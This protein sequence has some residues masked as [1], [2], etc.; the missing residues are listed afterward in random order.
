MRSGGTS[1][2]GLRRPDP[3][4]RPLAPVSAA[5]GCVATAQ[6]ARVCVQP[7]RE[8]ALAYGRAAG[9]QE[10]FHQALELCACDERVAQDGAQERS[11]AMR[12][13]EA[14][15]DDAGPRAD[16]VAHKA[17]EP[18]NEKTSGPAASNA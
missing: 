14:C 13:A 2:R 16:R 9:G 18:S 12:D 4:A 3:Q 1:R 15:M 8:A 17:H 11:Q 7:V 6:V 10:A 5:L